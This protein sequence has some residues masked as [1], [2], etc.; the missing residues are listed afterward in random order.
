MALIIEDGTNVPD[1][2]SFV[3]RQEFIDYAALRGV[4]L[5]NDSTSDV[6]LIKA[7][8]SILPLR[9]RFKGVETYD[10][11]S[12]PFP[13]TGVYINNSTT[14]IPSDVIPRDV[15]QA[16]M[17]LGMASQTGVDLN[18]VYDPSQ[19]FIIRE[20]VDVIETEY[21][22][23]YGNTGATTGSSMPVVPLAESL[24][25]AYLDGNS[26]GLVTRRV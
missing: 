22:N 14:P 10:D 8:D 3:T 26:F 24:L 25:A 6:F 11:Q 4:T 17:V 23:P 18:P 19:P 15:K 5:L 9:N 2:N 12:L 20:K 13:R 1:A 16:Q 7:M 21:A